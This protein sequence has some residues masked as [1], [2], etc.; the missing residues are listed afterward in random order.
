MISRN[1]QLGGRVPIFELVTTITVF[2]N[3]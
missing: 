1:I 2:Q 3:N